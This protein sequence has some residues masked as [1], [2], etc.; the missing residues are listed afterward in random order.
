M[1]MEVAAVPEA[2]LEA[3]SCGCVLWLYDYS[4]NHRFDYTM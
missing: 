1:F 3:V 4:R 2:A